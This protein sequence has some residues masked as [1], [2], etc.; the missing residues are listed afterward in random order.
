MD[1]LNSRM[2]SQIQ[3]AQISMERCVL[4][5]T[6]RDR[7]RNTWV[8][9]MPKVT[10]IAERVSR[11]DRNGRGLERP[12]SSSERLKMTKPEMELVELLYT[13]GTYF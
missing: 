1:V 7:K 5:I 6:R 3:C 2:L 11:L 13:I 4:G 10:D 12:S 9:S 8:R